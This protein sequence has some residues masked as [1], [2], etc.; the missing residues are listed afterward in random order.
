MTKIVFRENKMLIIHR[1][2][3]SLKKKLLKNK[4]GEDFWT[5]MGIRNIRWADMLRNETKFE[6]IWW[7]GR[8]KLLKRIKEKKAR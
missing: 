8:I 1:L 3:V 4:N 7:G 2:N 6:N 5:W